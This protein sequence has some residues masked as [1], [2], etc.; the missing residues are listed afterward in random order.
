MSS[1]IA[2]AG[3]GPGVVVESLA[4]TPSVR[5]TETGECTFALPSCSGD[6]GSREEGRNG[7]AELL[8]GCHVCCNG[9]VAVAGRIID[10]SVHAGSRSITDVALTVGIGCLYLSGLPYAGETVGRN[11]MC[12]DTASG[13]HFIS[14]EIP[15][16]ETLDIGET[17]DTGVITAVWSSSGAAVGSDTCASIATIVRTGIRSAASIGIVGKNAE[18]VDAGDIFTDVC[19]CTVTC[20]RT[21]NGRRGRRLGGKR[22]SSRRRGGGCRGNGRDIAAIGIAWHAL[23]GEMPILS[24]SPHGIAATCILKR[25]GKVTLI[26]SGTSTRTACRT[27]D[28]VGISAT[29]TTLIRTHA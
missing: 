28:A 20:L 8:D 23:N 17:G 3:T 14:T 5:K 4:T 27:I 25:I 19:I 24:A 9:D 29:L 12:A 11:R 15:I 21:L 1:S 26:C 2:A 6:E 18:T 13:T 16:I 10:I 7:A 22:R